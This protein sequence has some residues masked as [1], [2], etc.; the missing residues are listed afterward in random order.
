MLTDQGHFAPTG[1]TEQKP[2]EEGAELADNYYLFGYGVPP[3]DE[4]FG[5]RIRSTIHFPDQNNPIFAKKALSR[6]L[7]KPRD[8]IAPKEIVRRHRPH[9]RCYGMCS[10]ACG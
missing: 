1:S 5:L 2:Y 4:R 3:L 7:R 10:T 6:P 9:G 8:H